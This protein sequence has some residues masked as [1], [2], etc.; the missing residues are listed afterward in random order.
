MSHTGN[1]MKKTKILC[2]LGP[3]S[4]DEGTLS[5]MV[6]KGMNAARIN[7][8]YGDRS[9]YARLIRLVRRVSDIPV[10][11]D[12][13]GPEIRVRCDEDVEM[14]RG[15]VITVG[16]ARKEGIW[17]NRGIHD[18]VRLGDRVLLGDGRVETVVEGI[19]GSRIDLRSECE[20]TLTDGM[21]VNVPGRKLEMPTLSERDLEAVNL[22]K[23]EGV[24]YIALS[25]TRDKEDVRRLKKRIGKSDISVIAKIENRDGVDNVDSIIR[26]CEGVMIA[27]GDLGVEIPSEEIPLLQKELITKCNR[28]GK[29]SIVATEML[30]SMVKNPKPTRAETSDVANAV[31]DGADALMLSAESAVGGYP[32]ESVDAMSKIALNV[33]S[34]LPIKPLDEEVHDPISLAISKA[35]TTIIETVDVDKI[36][37]ATHSG[38]TAMLISNFRACKDII[39]ITDSPMTMKKLHLVYAVRPVQHTLF[40]EKNKVQ[41]MGKFCLENGLVAK[42]DM[43][44][45]TAGV[46]TRK[47]MT[48]LVEIHKVKE[49]VE[50]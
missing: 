28:Q 8:A 7:T 37:V 36:V 32:V 21:G 48:N 50:Y 35:V 43:V 20:C 49:L 2:T 31:I 38:Y 5:R 40:K 42:A 30:Q 26:E 44:L 10:V 13:K 15:Q 1:T 6:G 9:D 17:F 45:F 34:H 29:I 33:E 4:N 41:E 39:A 16:S 3:A 14:G 12:I 19:T 25:F 22:A 23:K 47:Q 24:E 11:L 27:R 46:Y 18:Q